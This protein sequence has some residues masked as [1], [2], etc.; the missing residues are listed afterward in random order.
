MSP[1]REGR[2]GGDTEATRRQRAVIEQAT[3]LELR[4]PLAKG[5]QDAFQRLAGKRMSGRAVS[6]AHPLPMPYTQNYTLCEQDRMLCGQEGAMARTVVAR[7]WLTTDLDS[8]VRVEAP[9]IWR[10]TV[11]FWSC[12]RF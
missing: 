7:S 5:A 9:P 2:R 11:T 6:T 1:A 12:A 8:T 4:D 3:E 10:A